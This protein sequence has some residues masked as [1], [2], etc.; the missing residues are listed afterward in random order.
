MA[1][2]EGEIAKHID[3]YNDRPRVKHMGTRA[4]GVSYAQYSEDWRIKVER[5]GNLNYPA[6]AKGKLYGSLILSVRIKE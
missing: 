4:E 2:F 3:E 6:A 5:V 1:R